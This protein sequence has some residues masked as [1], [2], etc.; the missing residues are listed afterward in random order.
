MNIAVELFNV[1][2]Q[3]ISFWPGMN[4]QKA[5]KSELSESQK[6]KMSL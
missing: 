4:V 2:L 3:T 1:D 5:V 6:P